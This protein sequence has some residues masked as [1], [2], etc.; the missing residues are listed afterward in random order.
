MKI[1]SILIVDD[2]AELRDVM[3][4]VLTLRGHQVTGAANGVEAS[5]AVANNR[6]DVVITDLIMPE[7]DGIQV[8][9]E[10]RRKYPEIKIVAMSGGGHISR[11]QYLRIAKGLGAHALLEKPFLNQELIDAIDRV[12]SPAADGGGASQS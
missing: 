7:R 5:R 1:A 2:E 12:L 3:T 9:N 11:D 6:F 4:R 10:L 8:I